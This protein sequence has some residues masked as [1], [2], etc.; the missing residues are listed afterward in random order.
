MLC[1]FYLSILSLSLHPWPILSRLSEAQS[2][3]QSVH[4]WISWCGTGSLVIVA[5]SIIPSFHYCIPLFHVPLN[6][7]SPTESCTARQSIINVLFLSSWRSLSYHGHSGKVMACEYQAASESVIPLTTLSLAL[8]SWT[9]PTEV[10]GCGSRDYIGTSLSSV[11]QY[12]RILTAHIHSQRWNIFTQSGTV[13]CVWEYSEQNTY[14]N[15]YVPGECI[16]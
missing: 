4:A 7:Y 13:T 14:A 15:G 10:G 3:L 1:G 2:W 16:R 9:T 12:H 8:V 5:H 11:V 6:L